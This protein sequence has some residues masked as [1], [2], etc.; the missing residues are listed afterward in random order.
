MSTANINHMTNKQIE[1]GSK[2][3][4]KVSGK[5]VVVEITAQTTNFKGRTQFTAINTVTKREI[6]IRSAAR[7]SPVVLQ[8]FTLEMRC[9]FLTPSRESALEWHA[10]YRQARQPEG[11]L[12]HGVGTLRVRLG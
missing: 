2:Y 12:L 3:L 4:A 8:R 7:L 6:V 1:V 10:A 11:L 9:G 5:T